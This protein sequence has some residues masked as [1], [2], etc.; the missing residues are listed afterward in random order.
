MI[1]QI[2]KKEMSGATLVI[3]IAEYLLALVII[4]LLIIILLCPY[5]SAEQ[6]YP[7]IIPY[8]NDFADVLS[9]AEETQIN[10]LCDA[11]EQ[12]TT[13]E[14]AV[15]TAVNTGGQDRVEYA[16]RL[17]DNSGVG[18]AD[19]DNGVV[20][21]WSFGD[22]VGGAIATGRGAESILNDAKVGEI[23]RASRHFFDEKNY[24]GG[25][26]Y[27]VGR[28]GN[29]LGASQ[30][31]TGVEQ[32]ASEAG[33]IPIGDI[34]NTMLFVI[35]FGIAGFV[36]ILILKVFIWPDY[37][38]E[39]NSDDSDD[40]NSS[41]SSKGS[42]RKAGSGSGSGGSGGGRGGFGGFSGGGFGGGGVGF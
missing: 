40:D 16:N 10:L 35:I 5:I 1:N 28:I 7:Q 34:N 20:V 30:N 14:I 27:I 15:V 13:F 22:D 18:K 9:P 29:V 42:G 2:K 12:Q 8:V 3:F 17:G 36:I 38:S 31:V 39:D 33:M 41:G 24:S 25:F 23:G 6:T 26:L 21:L 4:V 19:T 32:T 11:I 37:V